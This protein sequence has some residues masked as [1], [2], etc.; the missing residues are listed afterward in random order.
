M[1][2]SLPVSVHTYVLESHI[3]STKMGLD[4]K[5]NFII[6]FT[7]D[8]GD[9]LLVLINREKDQKKIEKNLEIGGQGVAKKTSDTNYVNMMVELRCTLLYLIY[10]KYEVELLLCDECASEDWRKKERR[11]KVE[12]ESSDRWRSEE[13]GRGNER[14]EK[15]EEKGKQGEV[16]VNKENSNM[17]RGQDN[18]K[19]QFNDATDGREKYAKMKIDLLGQLRCQ[20]K[21]ILFDMEPFGHLISLPVWTVYLAI[22]TMIVQSTNDCSASEEE[23]EK[24][25]NKGRGTSGEMGDITDKK[26]KFVTKY[27]V[28]QNISHNLLSSLCVKGMTMGSVM[29][30]DNIC[31]DDANLSDKNKDKEKKKEKERK[32]GKEYDTNV[33]PLYSLIV[34]QVCL[35]LPLPLSISVPHFASPNPQSAP[36]QPHLKK[37][38]ANDLKTDNYLKINKVNSM[39][40]KRLNN[41]EMGFGTRTFDPTIMLA[42]LEKAI[43]VIFCLTGSKEEEKENMGNGNGKGK[44]YNC[45][46]SNG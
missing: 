14:S 35:N 19:N 34:F 11:G 13:S 4:S 44:K 9:S 38:R 18:N 43:N 30:D 7:S 45:Y 21:M 28:S 16:G 8:I 2:R 10:Q 40:S 42:G 17:H 27:S 41:H 15:E 46:L 36:S 33:L 23:E 25:R 32:E 39:D 6:R 22:E 37:S 3:L 5:L 31:S 1:I 29:S 20:C 26:R 12:N 24:G